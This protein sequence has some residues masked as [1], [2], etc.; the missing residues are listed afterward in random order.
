MNIAYPYNPLTYSQC[1]QHLAL[2][3][4]AQRGML[5]RRIARWRELTGSEEGR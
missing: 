2:L 1:R 3:T 5:V 4:D